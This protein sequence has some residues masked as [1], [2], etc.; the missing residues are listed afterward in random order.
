MNVPIAMRPRAIAGAWEQFGAQ[1]MPLA[2]Y[3]PALPNPAPGP[4]VTYDVYQFPKEAPRPNT[5][6][7][8]AIYVEPPI[9][10]TVDYR[11]PTW[12]D[13]ARIEAST[14]RDMREPGEAIQ[15]RG[16]AELA[17]RLRQ[18]RMRYDRFL[19]TLRAAA[20][21]GHWVYWPRGA[22]QPAIEG[23]WLSDNYR[24][25][26]NATA[27]WNANFPGPTQE[28][29]R[30]NLAAIS[31]DF[32]RAIELLAAAGCMA[33]TALMSPATHDILKQNAIASGIRALETVFADGLN[34][35]F[36]LNI[37]VV[38]GTYTHPVTGATTS[39]I[40]DNQV[41]FL[42]SDN[43]RS[44]RVM[45]E[46]TVVNLE[47]PEG[48]YGVYFESTI[49]GKPPHYGEIVGEWTGAPECSVAGAMVCMTDVTAGP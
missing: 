27:A 34:E 46:C 40:P 10:A 8:E 17:R 26:N 39:Y 20:L 4:H 1:E 49:E 13:G 41:T 47:A 35:L 5:R 30:S 25:A 3:F 21:N 44:G 42:D 2:K 43:T 32:A 7:G 9:V 33:D 15:N 38:R 11:A 45:R 14:I 16:R 12:R 22:D 24:L 31:D 48:A 29:A 37:E 36:G 6:E 23:L 18:L 19:E 28:Q